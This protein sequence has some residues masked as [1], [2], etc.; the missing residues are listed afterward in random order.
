MGEFRSRSHTRQKANRNLVIYLILIALIAGLYVYLSY[1]E[2]G[3]NSSEEKGQSSRL[4]PIETK[5]ARRA[6]QS[7]LNLAARA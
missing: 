6:R 4:Q 7:L 3:K 1:L 2:T 5:E